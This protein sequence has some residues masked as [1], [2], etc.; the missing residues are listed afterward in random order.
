MRAVLPALAAG[1]CACGSRPEAYAPPEQRPLFEEY[2]SYFWNVVNMA[3]LDANAHIVRDIARGRGGS[4]RWTGQRPAVKL[5]LRSN[6][7]LKFSID[8]SI[9]G[10]TFKDTGPVTI[11]FYVNDHLVDQVHYSTPGSRHFEKPI[12]AGWITP[13]GDTILAAEIDKTWT[14]KEDGA[15]LGFILT[16]IGLIK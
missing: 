13:E 8:L 1:L 6:Q 9:A 3:D 10:A 11:S 12:P 14:S 7:R 5:R 2:H 16:R 15:R 4:W